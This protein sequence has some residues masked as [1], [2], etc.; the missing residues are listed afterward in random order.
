MCRA[1]GLRVRINRVLKLYTFSITSM[2]WL[3]PALCRS[4]KTIANGSLPGLSN[5]CMS[6][7][8]HG[9]FRMPVRFWC[10]GIVVST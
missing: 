5:L 10:L 1:S 9:L 7:V 4:R 6:L 8:Y 2:V 3:P